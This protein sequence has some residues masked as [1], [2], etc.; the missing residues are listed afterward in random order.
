MYRETI[1][2]RQTVTSD[3]DLVHQK[4]IMLLI[5]NIISDLSFGMLFFKLCKTDCESTH[6]SILTGFFGIDMIVFNAISIVIS[7][8]YPNIYK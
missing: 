2:L 6:I 1:M 4:V 8:K 5:S 3:S 7:S